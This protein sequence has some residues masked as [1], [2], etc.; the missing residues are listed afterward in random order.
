[1]TT[2]EKEERRQG[3]RVKIQ[4]DVSV[5]NMPNREAEMAC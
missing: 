1:M 5:I 2:T 3:A 4:S